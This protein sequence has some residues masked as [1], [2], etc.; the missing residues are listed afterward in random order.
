MYM[1]QKN[2]I[3]WLTG[4]PSTG[5]TTLAKLLLTKL[6]K[7]TF[8]IDGDDL[9]EIFD[10]KDYS[11]EGRLKNIETAQNIAKYLYNKGNNVIVSLVSPYRD[12]REFFKENSDV[13][14]FYIHAD[15]I[16]ER[17][18]YNVN[19]YEPPLN[20]FIDINT[21]IDSPE[22]SLQKILNIIDK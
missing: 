6:P 22:E 21:T 13:I 17:A 4:Q 15:D 14:E 12:Q 7:N 8:H 18:K 10:N 2:K 20:N 5:K 9:R 16:R 3:Y 1:Y 19:N 11:K